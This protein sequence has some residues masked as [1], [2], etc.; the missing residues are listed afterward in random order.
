MKRILFSNDNL[1]GLARL[2][3]IPAESFR[4]IKMDFST[5][6]RYVSVS[7]TEDILELVVPV[8][9]LYSFD[10]QMGLEDGSPFFDVRIEGIVPRMDTMPGVREELERGEWIVLHTDCNGT[11]RLSGMVDV[12]MTFFSHR[13]SG[14]SP[15]A[16]NANRFAFVGR[17]PVPSVEVEPDVIIE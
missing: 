17:E 15:S 11:S 4:R 9:G 10:E 14:P 16:L 5:G 3:V 8:G 6:K 2:I 13:V 12:P 1:G 7:S